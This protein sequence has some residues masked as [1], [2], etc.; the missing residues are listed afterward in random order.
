MICDTKATSKQLD[1]LLIGKV[2]FDPQHSCIES[3]IAIFNKSILNP[4]FQTLQHIINGNDLLSEIS[5]AAMCCLQQLIKIVY[6]TYDIKTH[7]VA[8]T[9][10]NALVQVIFK[11]LDQHVQYAVGIKTKPVPTSVVLA[12]LQICI[13]LFP[14]SFKSVIAGKQ[15]GQKRDSCTHTLELCLY[16]IECAV[17]PAA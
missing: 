13:D 4:I 14:N 15:T 9:T 2:C 8:I 5:V 6:K 12:T 11:K 17:V 7:Q 10:L 1:G 16:H 3:S